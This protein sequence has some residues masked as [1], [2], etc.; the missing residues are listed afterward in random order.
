MVGKFVGEENNDPEDTSRSQN[1]TN[2]SHSAACDDQLGAPH[3]TAYRD[4]MRARAF[5]VGIVLHLYYTPQGG[6]SKALS[7]CNSRPCV[8]HKAVQSAP[9][10]VRVS[11]P[12]WR[13]APILQYRE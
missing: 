8:Q 4:S 10:G 3:R 6:P 5:G 13:V 7:A 2:H 1:L 12:M 9:S 11:E